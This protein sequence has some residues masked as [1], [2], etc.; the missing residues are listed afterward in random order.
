MLN[1]PVFSSKYFWDVNPFALDVQQHKA[2]II[3]RLLEYG[4]IDSLTWINKIYTKEDIQDVVMR[5]RRITPK[6]G[7]FFSLY[8][9]IPKEN[10]LCMTPRSI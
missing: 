8:F 3:E 4:D 7:N 6:T 2:F 9:G 1:I 5:S 10:I